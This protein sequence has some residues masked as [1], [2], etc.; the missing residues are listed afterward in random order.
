MLNRM[1]Q[2]AGK[3]ALRISP[4]QSRILNRRNVFGSKF[5]RNALLSYLIEPFVTGENHSHQNRRQVLLLARA[6]ADKGL[7]IDVVDFRFEGSVDYSRYDVIIGFGAPFERSFGSGKRA[8]RIY[9]APAGSH[10]TSYG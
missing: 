10:A 9:Y 2:V 5:K 6:I 3:L 7:N 8:C 4:L 1:W